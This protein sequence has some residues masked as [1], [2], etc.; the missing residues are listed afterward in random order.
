AETLEFF[1]V[2]PSDTLIEITPGGGGWYAEILA[3]LLKGSGRYIGAIPQDASSEY[4]ARGNA[5]LRDKL[6]GNAEAYGEA[7]LV[8]FDPKAPSFG[9]AESADAV[10]TFR[11]VHNWGDNAPAMFK[12]FFEVLKPGGTLGVAE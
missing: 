10:V 5:K 12:G 2:K 7:T 11:N 4:A 3:P 8:E 9:A 6:A 1:G